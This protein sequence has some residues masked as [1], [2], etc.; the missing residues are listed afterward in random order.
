[1]FSHVPLYLDWRC[2][3]SFSSLANP[4]TEKRGI[5]PVVLAPLC[6]SDGIRSVPPTHTQVLDCSEASVHSG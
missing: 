1:M 2:R 3:S 6:V 5:T 4:V